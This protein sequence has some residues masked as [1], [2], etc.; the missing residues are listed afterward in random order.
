MP[1]AGKRALPEEKLRTEE[2][3]DELRGGRGEI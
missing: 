3:G 2:K 1:L